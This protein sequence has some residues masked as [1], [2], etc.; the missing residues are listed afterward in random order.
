MDSALRLL[1]A[2]ETKNHTLNAHTVDRI[3]CSE[4]Q[5]LVEWNRLLDCQEY[6][7]SSSFI[8]LLVVICQKLV[9]AFE[10]LV[11]CISDEEQRSDKERRRTGHQLS[12][13]SITSLGTFRIATRKE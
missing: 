2:L 10:K 13:A 12:G 11:H 7:A 4:K 6:V 5:A 1:G 9:W 3:L 8:T